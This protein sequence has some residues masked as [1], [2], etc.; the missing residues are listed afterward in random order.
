MDLEKLGWSPFFERE[1]EIY[2]EAGFEPLRVVAQQGN[3]YT[4][5]GRQGEFNGKVTGRMRYECAQMGD[6]PA[7]GDWIVAKINPETGSMFIRAVLPRKTKFT[8]ARTN[9]GGYIGEQVVSANLDVL[10]VVIGLDQDISSGRLQRYVAQASTSGAEIIII[11]NKSDLCL[12]TEKAVD[13]VKKA[14]GELPIITSSASEGTGLDEILK[15]LGPGK[16]GSLVGISGVGK[17]TLINAIL[18]EEQMKTG[19]VRKGDSKGRH[20][21]THRELIFLPGGGMLI[22][23][24]GMRGMG[25]DGDEEMVSAM[26]EDVEAVISRCK[27]SDCQHATEPGCAVKSAIA[28]GSLSEER[29]RSYIQFKKELY[30]LSVAKS[31]RSRVRREV[32]AAIKRRDQHLKRLGN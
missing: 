29:F 17:S 26:Y 18:G 7:V 20:T 15:Y 9:K 1:F 11:L 31:Q 22:D 14:A 21:T 3:I 5:V 8:R 2:R 32:S 24:P 25:L 27:F 28:N 23:N 4:A 30:I 10:L 16:T 6:Y 19:H 12:D 13:T